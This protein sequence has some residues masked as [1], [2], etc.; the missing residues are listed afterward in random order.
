[1]AAALDVTDVM[2][3]DLSFKLSNLVLRFMLSPAFLG[4]RQVLLGRENC[5]CLGSIERILSHATRELDG[6]LLVSAVLTH[7]QA[8]DASM[9]ALN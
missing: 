5:Q 7:E 3:P 6:D 4:L 2:L 9:R 1:M 8:F